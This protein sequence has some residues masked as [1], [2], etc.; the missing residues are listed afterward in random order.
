MIYAF[1]TNLGKD[2]LA[3][4]NSLISVQMVVP[5]KLGGFILLF[6]VVVVVFGMTR[7]HIKFNLHLLLGDWGAHVLQVWSIGHLPK[8][9]LRDCI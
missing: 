7:I 2:L 4:P 6:V 5:V 9:H 1:I 3:S 8:I